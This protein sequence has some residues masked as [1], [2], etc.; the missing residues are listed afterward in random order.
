MSNQQDTKKKNPNVPT[1]RFLDSGQWNETPLSSIAK[2]IGGGTP[3]TSV[4]TYWGGDIQWF[5]PSE[6]GKEKYVFKSERTITEKGLRESSAKL[7]PFGTILL[8]SRASIGPASILANRDG[9]TTNQGFQ[10]IVPNNSSDSEFIYYAICAPRIQKALKRKASGSTFPE[11]SHSEVERV[12]IFMPD[13]LKERSK[14]S[15]F[16][17]IIDRRIEVQNKII[18]TYSS[19]INPLFDRLHEGLLMEPTRLMD[20]AIIKKGEQINGDMM[21]DSNEFPMLNGGTTPSGFFAKSNRT[22]ET[23]AI[24]E[25][26]N[27][28]G[29]V[30]FMSTPFW[31]GGHCYTVHPASCGNVLNKYLFYSLKRWEREIMSLRVGSGLPNIQKSDLGNFIFNIPPKKRSG[32]DYQ[33][34]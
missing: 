21:D 2:I 5:T 34:A 13:N 25:G 26:G 28:C 32:S 19:L 31:A 10:S 6:V 20:V 27:S 14:I 22:K 16:L 30:S 17:T 18:E 11:I 24:S 9:A 29:Y 3:E 23:I 33:N 12:R 7:L 4:S 8:S 15:N 1:L